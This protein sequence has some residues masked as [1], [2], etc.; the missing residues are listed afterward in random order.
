[1]HLRAELVRSLREHEGVL[2]RDAHGTDLAG[3]GHVVARAE[4]PPD[5]VVGQA[6]SVEVGGVDVVDAELASAVEERHSGLAVVG[7]ALECH[8][9][10]ADAGDGPPADGGG[11]AGARRAAVLIVRVDLVRHGVL[12]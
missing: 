1:M 11:A 9:A 6:V 4:R 2:C 5:H 12:R 7:E 8:G 10:V 3:H